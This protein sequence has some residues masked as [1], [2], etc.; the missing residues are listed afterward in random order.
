MNNFTNEIS[1]LVSLLDDPDGKVSAPVIDRLIEI[2]QPAVKLLENYWENTPDQS[3]QS[4]IES[5]ILNIQRSKLKKDV[6][7]WVD[8]HGEQLLYGA[9]LVARTKYPGLSYNILDA[10]VDLLKTE[11]WLELNDHLTALEKV[12]VMNHFIFSVHKFTRT[13]KGILSPQLFHINH[14]LEA[15]K[16]IPITLA[17]LYAEIASRLELPIKC[18]DLPQNFLLAYHDPG[19]ADDPDGILFY[20]NPFSNG[21]VLGREE[22]TNFLAKQKL[23]V[24]ASYFKPCSNIV[25]IR[26]LTEGL[27]YTYA[28]SQMND[29]AE[30]LNELLKIINRGEDDY[31]V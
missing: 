3:V 14:L 12:K 22:L 24:E 7:D 29:E 13:V 19:Y 28:A 4:K 9:T 2:G 23:R 15:K 16:G 8:C 26:R 6:K 1:A 10:K 18:V 27:K 30:F 17:I 11:I 5:V 25:T 21:A 20:I 31:L